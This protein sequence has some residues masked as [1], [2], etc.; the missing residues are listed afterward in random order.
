[1]SIKLSNI[2]EYEDHTVIIRNSKD[3]SSITGLMTNE[4]LALFTSSIISES[5]IASTAEGTLKGGLAAIGSKLGGIVRSGIDSNFKTTASTYKS[6]TS[7][8]DTGF[9][10]SFIVYLKDRSINSILNTM[11]KWTQPA[12][13]ST[14]LRSQLYDLSVL[15]QLL[16]FK[17]PFKGQ[18]LHVSI[19]KYFLATG[20]FCTGLQYTVPKYVDEDGKPLYIEFTTS[21]LPYKLLGSEE[22]AS[23]FTR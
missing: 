6:Y 14:I 5:F 8:S 11:L 15:E 7:T 13:D 4:S 20:L 23:W 16:S 22:L 10:V 21:F 18:L 1:M 12:S 19:G 9:S 3:G 17:D 2:D